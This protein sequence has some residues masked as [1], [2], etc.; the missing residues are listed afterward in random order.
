MVVTV[1]D[2]QYGQGALPAN[3]Y[4]DRITLELA[5]WSK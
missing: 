4:Y 5:I 3:S 2:V 1:V